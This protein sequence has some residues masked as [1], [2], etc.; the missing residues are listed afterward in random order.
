MS[1][2]QGFSTVHLSCNASGDLSY[3]FD[4]GERIDSGQ[5]AAPPAPRDTPTQLLGD[6]DSLLDWLKSG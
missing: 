5:L 3:R 1:S 4:E 2:G 6:L